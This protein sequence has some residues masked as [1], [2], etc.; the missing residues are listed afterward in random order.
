M[1][2]GENAQLPNLLGCL[3]CCGKALHGLCHVGMCHRGV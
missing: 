2:V 1:M 3:F